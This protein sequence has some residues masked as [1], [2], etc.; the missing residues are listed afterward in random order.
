MGPH[1]G[2]VTYVR[3]TSASARPETKKEVLGGDESLG[4]GTTFVDK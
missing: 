4:P 1:L 3:S 2:A